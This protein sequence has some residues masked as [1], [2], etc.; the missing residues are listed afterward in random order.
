LMISLFYA[1]LYFLACIPYFPTKS[2]SEKC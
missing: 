2:L 1:S